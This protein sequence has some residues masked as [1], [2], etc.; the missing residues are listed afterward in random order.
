M[1]SPRLPIMWLFLA[2]TLLFAQTPAASRAK[3]KAAPSPAKEQLY[4]LRGRIIASGIEQPV[5]SALITFRSATK[6]TDDVFS[7]AKG[8][9]EIELPPGDYSYEV[10]VYGYEL[11]NGARKGFTI[12]AG[13]KLDP[14]TIRMLRAAEV[15]GIVEDTGGH[16]L[17][18]VQVEILNT[19]S[20]SESRGGQTGTDG[21]FIIGSVLPGSYVIRALMI[22]PAEDASSAFVTT[23]YPGTTDSFAAGEVMLIGDDLT[24]VRVRM[25]QAELHSVRGRVTGVGTNSSATLAVG[26]RLIEDP[27]ATGILLNRLSLP[28]LRNEIAEDGTF[29]FDNVAPGRY[30]AT[31]QGNPAAFPLAATE[32]FTV[33]DRDIEDLKMT[34]APSGA[35][36]GKIVSENGKL[37][38]DMDRVILTGQTGVGR[39]TSSL[40]IKK[41]GSFSMDGI[42]DGRY[43]ISLNA[44]L[45]YSVSSVEVNGRK[46]EGSRFP[47]T[48]PGS[49]NVV[50]TLSPGGALIQGSLTGSRNPDQ[51][52]K[53]TA[54]AVMLS[55]LSDGLFY[56]RKATL[57]ASGNFTLTDLEA[58]KYLVCA[59]SDYSMRVDR[60]LNSE[61]APVERLQQLCKTV[62]LMKDGAEPV[63]VRLTSMA[64][65]T[66]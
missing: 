25:Q 4:T 1:G 18:G 46:Y 20:V 26:L 16:P 31:V 47:M 56:V 12:A 60:L 55:G 27:R 52:V 33:R 36:A 17:A 2:G 11:D 64:D 40:A 48:V 13:K 66:R 61:K 28:R 51:P 19:A 58:G 22:T 42:P 23:Y 63:E 7:N 38:K 43:A 39:V 9:F 37:P 32:E 59:W 29:S 41:D 57:A 10:K 50:V 15:S 44:Q 3:Q 35:L 62:E 6:Y 30:V 21:K 24:N 34:V 54:T 65:V 53:G 5:D 8:E 49:S 45:G 14:L